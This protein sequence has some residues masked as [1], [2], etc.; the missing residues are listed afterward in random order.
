MYLWQLLHVCT[1][2]RGGGQ[3]IEC[4]VRVCRSVHAVPQSAHRMFPAEVTETFTVSQGTVVP[5][6]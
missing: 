3:C 4:S 6:I 2:D 1:S 5:C